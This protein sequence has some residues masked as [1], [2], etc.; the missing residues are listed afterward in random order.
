M[1]VVWFDREGIGLRA[2]IKIPR[3]K[4]RAAV[5]TQ[6]ADDVCDG[7]HFRFRQKDGQVLWRLRASVCMLWHWAD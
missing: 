6:L 2:I 5:A 7:S 1:D 3:R 4:R